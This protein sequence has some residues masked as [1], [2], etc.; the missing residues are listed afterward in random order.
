MYYNGSL[1]WAVVLG[2]SAVE[3]EQGEGRVGHLVVPPRGKLIMVDV[4]DSTGAEGGLKGR[5]RGVRNR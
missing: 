4:V 1:V 3:F 5:W 2:E